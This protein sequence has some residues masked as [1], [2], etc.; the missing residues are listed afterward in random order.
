MFDKSR[1]TAEHTLEANYLKLQCREDEC[2]D[3]ISMEVI[4]NDAPNFLLPMRMMRVNNRVEFRYTMG[5]Q[6]ALEYVR[7]MNLNKKQFLNL[8]NN[9]LTP[10]IQ[11][12]DWMLDYHYLC[13]DMK[14]VLI[15]KD[16]QS[17]NYM[18]IPIKSCKNTDEE[19]LNFF[20]IILSKVTLS[21]GDD[22]LLKL[23]R[24]FQTGNITLQDLHQII[25]DEMKENE[26]IVSTPQPQRPP[27][28]HEP[29]PLKPEPQ[30]KAPKA[31]VTQPSGKQEHEAQDVVG[32]LFGAKKEPKRSLFGGRKKN[33]AAVEQGESKRSIPKKGPLQQPKVPE[34]SASYQSYEYTEPETDGHT[35]VFSDEKP[36]GAYLISLNGDKHGVPERIDLSFQKDSIMIGRQSR[37][38]I[39]PDVAFGPEHV[40]IGRMHA[41]IRRKNGKYYVIDLGSGNK[42][43]FNG[44]VMVSNF[45]Y[46]LHNGDVIGFVANAPF[47]YKAV[48]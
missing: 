47:S 16:W 40:H 18:Y 3:H 14:C 1:I 39:Q 21:D 13:V 15:E 25:Q 29:M 32:Q 23:Y 22:I 35:V 42:T 34:T 44:E 43:S 17:V 30:V 24:L 46:E 4:K 48:L 27:V 38:L 11:C 37:D 2:P 10:F 36:E 8:Y 41:C 28:Q 6:T 7:T 20:N 5:R 12:G 19:I 31:P 26:K 45:E 9:F 33:I